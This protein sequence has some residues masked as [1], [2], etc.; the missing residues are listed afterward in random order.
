[1][2]GRLLI[3]AVTVMLLIVICGMSWMLWQQD[4]LTGNNA[5]QGSYDRALNIVLAQRGQLGDA[6]SAANEALQ[7]VLLAHPSGPL[8]DAARASYLDSLQ[9]IDAERKAW[10]YPRDDC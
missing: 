9:T 4:I 6:S 8:A 3:T 10:P 5:C 7:A 1:M 2:P